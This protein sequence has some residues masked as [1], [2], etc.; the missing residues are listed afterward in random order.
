M[1][2]LSDVLGADLFEAVKEKLKDEFVLVE[3]SDFIPKSRFD[4]INTQCKDLKSELTDRDTQLKELQEKSK[5]ND[6][7]SAQITELQTR[8]QKVIEDYERQIKERDF[9]YAFDSYL[10]AKGARNVKAA[11][12][13]FDTSKIVLESGRLVGADEQFEQI[14]KENDY[15]FKST[16][17][18][19]T[20]A[21]PRKQTPIFQDGFDDFLKM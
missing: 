20:G 5:G 12:A 3:K 19:N 13:L 15:L 11:R 2:N 8:N 4:E 18:T 7:L 14:A 10:S 6:Q 21:D 16:V 9:N 17:P 1:K